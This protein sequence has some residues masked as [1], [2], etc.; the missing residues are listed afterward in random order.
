MPLGFGEIVII[1]CVG[2][3]VFIGPKKVIPKLAETMKVAR[4]A[5]QEASKETGASASKKTTPPPQP[6]KAPK[7]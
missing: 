6:P 3:A 4:Q 1:G 2:A 7:E 5:I